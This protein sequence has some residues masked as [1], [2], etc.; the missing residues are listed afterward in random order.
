MY[1]AVPLTEQTQPRDNAHRTIPQHAHAS[2]NTPSSEKQQIDMRAPLSS[3]HHA[4]IS[5]ES[6]S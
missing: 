6:K 2:N 3:I 5:F 1:H 4:R